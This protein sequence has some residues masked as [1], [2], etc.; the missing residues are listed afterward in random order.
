MAIQSARPQPLGA[1]AGLASVSEKAIVI[2]SASFALASGWMVG[3]QKVSGLLP[4]TDE[5]QPT[6][7]AWIARL[8]SGGAIDAGFAGG[9]LSYLPTGYS[10]AETTALAVDASGRTLAAVAA[11]SSAT[12]AQGA[13]WVLRFTATGALDTT[14]GTGG[15]V[16][17]A[18]QD[19]GSRIT[20]LT[21]QTSG[22]ILALG[23]TKRASDAS[24]AVFVAALLSSNGTLDTSFGSGGKASIAMGGS[25]PIPVGFD[26]ASDGRIALVAAGATTA[27]RDVYVAR[28][29]AA[30]VLD[31]GF[32]SGGIA[33]IHLSDAAAR[34][35]GIGV[36]ADNSMVVAGTAVKGSGA[37][38]DVFFAKLT[39]AGALDSTFGTG[40]VARVDSGSAMLDLRAGVLPPTGTL[41][42]A[43]NTVEG[44]A[45]R[46]VVVAVTS[47]GQPDTTLA[48]GGKLLLDATTLA[49]R[50]VMSAAPSSNRRGVVLN[51]MKLD[52][53]STEFPAPDLVTVNNVT[54]DDG[55]APPQTCTGTFTASGPS[56]GL[57]V[58]GG[59]PGAADWEWGL[60]YNTQS[61]GKFTAGQ[62]G[63]VSG[64]WTAFTLTFDGQGNATVIYPGMTLGYPTTLAGPIALGNAVKFYVKASGTAPAS[65]VALRIDRINAA[66]GL[67][68]TVT[69]NP[70]ATTFN[71]A[72]LVLTSSSLSSGLEIQGAVQLNYFG[73]VPSGS[74][75]GITVSPGN[76]N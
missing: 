33:R 49:N 62:Y 55:T 53:A 45:N 17:V 37:N 75:L 4:A 35:V 58:R 47:A 12:T 30:G 42:A 36:R 18:R 43:G 67:N 9:G 61:A 23:Y 39:T 71:E 64:Q 28:M 15:V 7:S 56:R 51:T 16:E 14:F 8:T 72:A 26:V 1:A 44:N 48:S 68:R 21:V 29:T 10:A 31:S 57:E 24:H 20:N 41:A 2:P 19:P 50:K 76:C 38:A 66:S 22:R 52:P 74:R 5:A 3:G 34:P 60:G 13:V 27:G 32:G 25:Q 63:W 54:R 65:S 40:G 69:T 6:Y 73:T 59:K 70:S 46:V 11:R